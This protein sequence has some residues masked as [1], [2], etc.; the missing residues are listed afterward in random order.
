MAL[1]PSFALLI[2]AVGSETLPTAI[3]CPALLTAVSLT[4]IATH[5]DREDRTALWI[6]AGSQAEDW[7]GGGGGR[8][9]HGAKYSTANQEMEAFSKLFRSTTG[10]MMVRLRRDDAVASG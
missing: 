6:D 1:P 4:A 8:P 7:L 10:P 2:A 3:R 9:G 5:A